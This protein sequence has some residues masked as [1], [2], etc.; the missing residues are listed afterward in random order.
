M[1]AT[2]EKFEQIGIIPVVVLED[3]KDAAPSA[4]LCWPAAC[5]LPK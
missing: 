5:L 4:R 1:N 3:V 2:F